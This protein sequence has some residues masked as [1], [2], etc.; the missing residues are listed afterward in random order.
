MSVF[1]DH[2]IHSNFAGEKYTDFAWHKN[3][4]LLA[5]AGGSQAGGQTVAIFQQEVRS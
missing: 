1:F 4:G 5:V 2:Q 3:Y